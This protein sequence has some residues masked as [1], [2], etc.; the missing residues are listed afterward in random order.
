MSKAIVSGSDVG[1]VGV[2]ADQLVSAETAAAAARRGNSNDRTSITLTRLREEAREQGRKQGYEEG[3]LE[4]RNEGRETFLKA[5]GQLLQDFADRLG[6]RA[7]ELEDAIDAWFV[8]AEEQLAEVALLVAAK[9][10][11][12]EVKANREIVAAIAR[13]ALAEVDHVKN[14]RIRVN[15]IDCE[16]LESQTETILSANRSLRRI[17]VVPDANVGG[18]CIVES[19]AGEIDATVSTRLDA[20][21]RAFREAA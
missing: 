12:A 7:A 1:K 4:G 20:I 9:V 19:D 16:Y 8:A 13:D 17:E 15:L 5:H 3:L 21:V 10:I 18:G 6:A 14:V 2:F 11:A